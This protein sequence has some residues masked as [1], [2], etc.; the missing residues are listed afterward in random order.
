MHINLLHKMPSLMDMEYFEDEKI[1]GFLTPFYNTLDKIRDEYFIS[2]PSNIKK[3]VDYFNEPDNLTLY[4]NQM[5]LKYGLQDVAQSSSVFI[6]N[7]NISSQYLHAVEMGMNIMITDHQV[8]SII[9]KY[10]QEFFDYLRNNDANDLLAS[11]SLRRVFQVDI[12]QLSIRENQLSVTFKNEY[13]L[14]GIDYDHF[15]AFQKNR[16]RY[17]C[18]VK[19]QDTMRINIQKTY[20]EELNKESNHE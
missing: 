18:S 20:H 14:E 17:K 13:L 7:Y 8:E 10:Q 6:K 2:S 1:F 4:C 11:H 12:D 19:K 15:N 5:L 9:E 3:I 16:F